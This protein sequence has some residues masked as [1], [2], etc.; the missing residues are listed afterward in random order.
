MQ[1]RVFCILLLFGSLAGALYEP[2]RLLDGLRG[3]L[4]LLII[5]L[6]LLFC[7]F[8]GA[9][10]LALSLAFC[11]KFRL[12]HLFGIASGIFLYE[13][14]FHKTVAFFGKMVYNA[15]VKVI[16]KQK[17]RALW[18]QRNNPSPRKKPRGSQ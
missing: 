2:L 1:L 10:Y 4:R 7:L 16:R 13:K 17:D 14:S 12:F 9:G 15:H 6:D 8:I 3:R 18:K 5:F 11:G